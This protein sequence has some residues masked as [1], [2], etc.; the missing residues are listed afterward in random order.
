VPGVE[1]RSFDAPD[2]TR[3]PSKTK[4][5]MVRLGGA[6]AARVT[7]EPGWTWAECIKPIAGTESCQLRH[8]GLAQSGAMGVA[9]ED[10]TE[11]EIRGG[12]AYVIEPGHNAW[13]VGDEPFVGFEFEAPSAEKFGKP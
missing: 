5:E 2:E 9:H 12:Q 7:L 8:V 1:T 3:T 4:V 11:Q 13:V 10:G 6:S